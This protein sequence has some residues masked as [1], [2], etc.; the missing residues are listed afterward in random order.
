MWIQKEV[1]GII[2]SIV[3]IIQLPIRGNEEG[4]LEASYIYF[5]PEKKNSGLM[6]D[7]SFDGLAGL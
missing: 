2:N 6:N 4:T 5:Q 1:K 3:E 7:K